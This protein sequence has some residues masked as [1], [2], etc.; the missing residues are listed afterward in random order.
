MKKLS[1]FNDEDI[2][3][4]VKE[5]FT[6]LEEKENKVKT[7]EWLQWALDKV[8]QYRKLDDEGVAYDTSWSEEDKKKFYL[9]SDFHSYLISIASKLKIEYQDYDSIFETYENN[10]IYNGEEYHIFTM[11]GQGAVTCI[12]KGFEDPEKW[13]PID[14]NNYYAG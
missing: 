4:F 14:L 12:S 1:E 3:N 13:V 10:F 7:K 2:Q 11:I 9:I 5:Y 8:N 6:R